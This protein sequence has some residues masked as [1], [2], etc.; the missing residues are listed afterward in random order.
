MI[1]LSDIIKSGGG[2]AKI[3]RFINRYVLS[4]KEKKDIV[5]EIKTKGSSSD[6][7]LNNAVYYK[8]IKEYHTGDSLFEMLMS[9]TQ[10][11][12]INEYSHDFDS[13]GYI[14]R[15]C[16]PISNKVR[17]NKRIFGLV[18]I[19]AKINMNGQEMSINSFEEL[20]S[21]PEF[22]DYGGIQKDFYNNFELS[23]KEE[24]EKYMNEQINQ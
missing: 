16:M 21:F 2:N 23:T 7:S 22:N 1:K 12:N 20:F 15:Y 10:M 8:A 5:N 4:K 17:N 13:G 6:G 24:I 9:F 11:L 14:V 19:P 3:N 18:V